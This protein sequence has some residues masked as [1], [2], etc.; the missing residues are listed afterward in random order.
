MEVFSVFDK[1]QYQLAMRC[2]A[3]S[4]LTDN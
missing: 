1:N 2:E 4:G 3:A